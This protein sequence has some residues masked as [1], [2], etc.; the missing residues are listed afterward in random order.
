M[1]DHCAYKNQQL[2]GKLISPLYVRD[3]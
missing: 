3:L 1:K 2:I